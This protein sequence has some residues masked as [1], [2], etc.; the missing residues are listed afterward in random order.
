MIPREERREAMENIG[1]PERTPDIRFDGQRLDEIVFGLCWDSLGGGSPGEAV[2]LDAM[3][4]LL[5]K[6]DNA[7]QVIDAAHPRSKGDC[8]IHTGDSLTGASPW[9]DERIFVFL[10][11]L[12]L[13][14]ESVVFIV[15]CPTGRALQTPHAFCHISD[16]VSE[17]S[18]AKFDLSALSEHSVLAVATLKRRGD[19]WQITQGSTRVDIDKVLGGSNPVR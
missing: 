10:G 15:A 4:V 7:L 16:R 13:Q 2:N 18:W 1:K 14:V 11:M 9:D 12:S 17:T 3:C 19:G 8:V 6:E 5:D